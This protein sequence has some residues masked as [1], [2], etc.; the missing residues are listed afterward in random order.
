MNALEY[1]RRALQH[2]PTDLVTLRAEAT[3]LQ[4]LGLLPRDISQALGLNP[5]QVRQLIQ[6]AEQ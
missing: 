1:Q 2:R 5:E 4:R 3:K 6:D